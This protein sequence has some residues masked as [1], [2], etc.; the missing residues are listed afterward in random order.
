MQLRPGAPNEHLILAMPPGA[1]CNPPK[2]AWAGSARLACSESGASTPAPPCSTSEVFKAV[3]ERLG[4]L[5]AAPSVRLL[6]HVV[7]ACCP[8]EGL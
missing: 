6:S 8:D 7:Q 3:E 4:R 2:Q 5:S 1:G